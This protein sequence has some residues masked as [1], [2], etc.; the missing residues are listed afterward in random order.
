MRGL[1]FLIMVIVM[2]VL[3]S[4]VSAITGDVESD[5]YGR[6]TFICVL[7]LISDILTKGRD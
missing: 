3:V 7:Y 5:I 6:F 1:T 4:A 2:T